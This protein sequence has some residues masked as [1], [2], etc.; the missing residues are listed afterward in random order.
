MR[1]TQPG[2]GVDVQVCFLV[3]AVLVALVTTVVFIVVTAAVVEVI[4]W[5][6]TIAGGSVVGWSAINVTVFGPDMV[7]LTASW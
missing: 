5:V 7:T 2:S 1:T 3:G 6:V 4:T